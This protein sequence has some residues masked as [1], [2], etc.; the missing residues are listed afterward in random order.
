ML[1]TS[2]LVEVVDDIEESVLVPFIFLCF[3]FFFI[4]LVES[5]EVVFCAKTT[6]PDKQRKAKGGDHDFFHF[7]RYLLINNLLIALGAFNEYIRII[8]VKES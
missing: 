4:V 7:M 1:R 2:Y 5:E 3:I 8:G 6:V